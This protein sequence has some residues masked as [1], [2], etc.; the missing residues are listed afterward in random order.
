MRML[1]IVEKKRNKGVLNE[2][3]IKFFIDGYVAGNI[4]DYQVSAL[5][6]SIYFNGMNKEE[7]AFLTKAMLYSGDLIDLSSIK[8]VKVDK[9]STGGVGDK[10]SLALGPMVAACGAKLAKMS[11]R[12]LGH[13]G[14]TLDKMESIPG[15]SIIKERDAFIE[16]VNDIGIA[17]VGQSGHL[18]PADKKLYALRDVTCT[19]DSI[20]LIASSIMSKKLASG[21]DTILL[22]VK[23]GSGAFMKDLESAR[24]LAHTMVD[25]GDS[26]KKDTRAMLSDMDQPLG[27]A[28]GNSLEVIEAVNTLK[29]HGPKDFVELCFCAGSIMLVQAKIV[30]TVEE[31]RKML[32]EKIDDGS[33]FIKLKEFIAAQGG[34]T[35]YLDDT[36]KFAVAKHIIPV[37]SKEKGYINYINA[38]EVGEYAMKLGAGR[39]TLEDV[40]DNA[41]GIIL[42]KKIGDFVNVGD[43][44]CYIHTNKED[45]AEIVKGLAENFI[46]KAIK[47]EEHRVIYEV[48]V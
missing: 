8:G 11:G 40:I 34:D 17:I 22:D 19:V 25:I 5:L 26:F 46:I 32:Q 39:E 47:R 9:H 10:T 41:A 20:P 33:A 18:V 42:E 48:I 37:C 15:L 29:G 14:G 12:G 21:S 16:Q 3:E 38:S 7:I 31:G 28:V 24:K 13:T 45:Y 44:L 27:C 6:M 2:Q 23:V 4:P 36:S 35:T 1:D 43:V 30:K